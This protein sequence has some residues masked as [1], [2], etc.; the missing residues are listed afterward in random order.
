[1]SQ[2]YVRCPYARHSRIVFSTRCCATLFRP[3]AHELH[4][5]TLTDT[6]A[7]RT[8]TLIS[9]T[10]LWRRSTRL[11]QQSSTS[12]RLQL[13]Q[14]IPAAR[15]GLRPTPRPVRSTTTWPIWSATTGHVL[16]ARAAAPGHVPAAAAKGRR[17]R[18]SFRRSVC[19][20]SMLLLSRLLVLSGTKGRL[21]WRDWA[22]VSGAEERTWLIVE[23]GGVMAMQG[24]VWAVALI[25][26][27]RRPCP[28]T[29]K[30]IGRQQFH[31][32][33]R[34]GYFRSHAQV[35]SYFLDFTIS[36]PSI[37]R[38]S[39]LHIANII[40]PF[41][42]PSSVSVLQLIVHSKL[43][44]AHLSQ[45]HPSIIPLIHSI[46]QIT[47]TPDETCTAQD[48]CDNTAHGGI[49]ISSAPNGSVPSPRN[50]TSAA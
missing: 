3:I 13:A 41:P 45:L 37:M 43:I 7:G 27:T 38:A 14:P 34:G 1:M 49:S 40:I 4:Q 48:H 23:E 47:A 39:E 31:A 18:R 6:T 24:G 26:V 17:W 21:R 42:M 2:K 20:F 36:F 50:R 22:R 30:S 33:R 16:P 12:R 44:L 35:A 5:Q 32:S 8:T 29:T 9:P 10:G 11:L 25:L 19:W 28:R 15:P 46:L